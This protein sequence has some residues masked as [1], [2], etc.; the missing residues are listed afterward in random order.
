MQDQRPCSEFRSWREIVSDPLTRLVMEADHVTPQGVGAVW[1]AAARSRT[2]TRLGRTSSQ[3]A[4]QSFCLVEA[5]LHGEPAV[6][7]Q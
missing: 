4:G 2:R 1:V 7:L 3:T 5:Q 6:T